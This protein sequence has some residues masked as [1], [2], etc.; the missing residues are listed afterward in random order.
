[1]INV[2]FAVATALTALMVGGLASIPAQAATAAPAGGSKPAVTQ[3]GTWDGQV[4][5]DG[6]HYDDVGRACPESSPICYDIVA[7]YRIVPLNASA[8]RAVKKLAGGPARLTGRLGPAQDSHHT[9]TL[10][11]R[12]A[13]RPAPIARTVQVDESNNGQAVTLRPGDHLTVV[14][15]STYW[16]FD[17]PS[18]PGVVSADGDPVYAA[19]G[20]KCGPPGSGCGTVTVHYTAG[21]DGRA[22]VSASRTSCG[23]AMRCTPA[24]SRW[25]VKVN[26]AG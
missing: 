21:H 23:E 17:A 12:T 20:P 4:Q 13:G 8:A 26:V 19:G 24:Q 2:R 3:T 1:M 6:G 15:H 7:R 11:V 9:G 10:F 18:D 16:Q 14:L 22:V 5:K 25:S